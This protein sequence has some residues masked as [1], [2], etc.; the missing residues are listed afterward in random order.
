VLKCKD[1]FGNVASTS[2]SA[3]FFGL[4]LLIR[5]PKESKVIATECH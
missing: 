5:D 2:G 3:I 4:R 1:F